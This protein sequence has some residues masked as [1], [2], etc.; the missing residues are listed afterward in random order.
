M[1]ILREY[2]RVK[3]KSM[4]TRIRLLLTFAVIFIVNTYA[5]FSVNEGVKMGGLQ[6]D[7]TPWYVAYYV[8][9]D[10]NE[11]VNQ[12]ETFTIEE[13]YP[14][15]PD[16]E[17]VV[18][19]YNIGS[20][21]TSINYELVSVKVFGQEVLGELIEQNKIEIIEGENE[22]TTKIFS[23]DTEISEDKQNYPFNISYTYDKTYLKGEYREGNEEAHA[24][25]RFNISWLYEIEGD[26]HMTAKDLLDTQFGKEA[27]KYYQDEANDP[28]KAIE[29]QVKITSNMIHPS[30]ES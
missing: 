3:K 24:T 27:Y 4:A 16:S 10:K 29:V 8:N 19:I 28:T 25:F 11:T 21:S 30:L 2:R 14:G 9:E 5:W 12:V 15:M 7:V 20:T 13:L 17:D 18:H 22:V 26:E 6:G 1:N 23:G